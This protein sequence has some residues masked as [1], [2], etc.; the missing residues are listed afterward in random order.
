[1]DLTRPTSVRRRWSIQ[2]REFLRLGMAGFGTLGLPDLLRLRAAAAT[3][4]RERTALIVIWLQGGT[5][6][7]ETYDPKPAA[8]TEIRGPYTAI[9]TRI[10]GLR[11]SELLPCH[12]RVAEARRRA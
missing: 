1:M 4:H 7:L 12:A 9:S 11:I 6:H 2:R 10:P 8:P 5:S 3:S